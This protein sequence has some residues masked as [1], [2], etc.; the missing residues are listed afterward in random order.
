MPNGLIGRKHAYELSLS[1]LLLLDDVHGDVGWRRSAQGAVG[2]HVPPKGTPGIK[3]RRRSSTPDLGGAPMNHSAARSSRLRE[4][5]TLWLLVEIERIA[6]SV[7]PRGPVR[8]RLLA[9]VNRALAQ[10]HPE[11]CGNSGPN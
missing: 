9:R 10:M 4:R 7:L 11:V 3:A 6:L 5:V 8:K 2:Q 1:G